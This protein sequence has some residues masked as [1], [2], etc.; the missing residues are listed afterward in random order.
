D[1]IRVFHVTGVQTCALP[2]SGPVEVRGVHATGG[3][4]GAIAAAP[5]PDRAARR[6]VARETRGMRQDGGAAGGPGGRPHRVAAYVVGGTRSEERRVGMEW[7]V[8]CSWCR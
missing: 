2:L 6:P 4:R 1:G 8:R 5:D 3:A 7:R